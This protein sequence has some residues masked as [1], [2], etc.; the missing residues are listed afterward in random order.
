MAIS[1]YGPSWGVVTTVDS[2]TVKVLEVL[3]LHLSA[4]RQLCACCHPLHIATL[5]LV[6]D[7][8]CVQRPPPVFS[9][10]PAAYD[11]PV[12]CSYCACRGT[13][14]LLWL[15]RAITR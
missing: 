5:E 9:V 6:P 7:R 14:T 3:A 13:T 12:P 15:D 1:S 11:S 4:G 10:Q 8:Q 2:L